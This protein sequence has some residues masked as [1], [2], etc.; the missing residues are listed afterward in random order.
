MVFK[1]KRMYLLSSNLSEKE[2]IEII[3]VT[4]SSQSLKSHVYQVLSCV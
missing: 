1:I 3:F 4:F 2:I